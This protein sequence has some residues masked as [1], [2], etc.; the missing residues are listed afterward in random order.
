MMKTTTRTLSPQTVAAW[1]H[2]PEAAEAVHLTDDE[3]RAQVV[4]L[5]T[6]AGGDEA[7]DIDAAVAEA[8]RYLTTCQLPAEP[9]EAMTPDQAR[10]LRAAERDAITAARA[11]LGLPAPTGTA[12]TPADETEESPF[13]LV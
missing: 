8:R 3:L 10:A 2:L 5:I 4:D 1:W 12:I 13:P 9:A 6:D 11:P 7:I